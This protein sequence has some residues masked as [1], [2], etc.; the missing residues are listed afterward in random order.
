[1]RKLDKNEN[2]KYYFRT[3]D[4]G[5]IG[6][7]SEIKASIQK[8]FGSAALQIEHIGSTSVEGMS[9]K[10]LIDVL[11]IVNDTRTLSEETS[12]MEQAGYEWGKDYIEP[13][14]ILFFKTGSEGEKIQNIHVLSVGSQ[15]A[16]QF[17]VTRD[18]LRTHPKRAQAYS[19][20][21]E[22]NMK[23]Y[24][25]NY[26]AYRAAKDGFLQKLEYDAYSWDE[27]GRK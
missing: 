16:R 1:M 26:I 6:Q 27:N 3:Y 4:V 11:V 24:P 5:W 21:K 22:A 10:P 19:K 17:L 23:L 9:A 18:F 7:F 2:R 13:N 25:D 15:K 20:L 12:H 14:S 8:S